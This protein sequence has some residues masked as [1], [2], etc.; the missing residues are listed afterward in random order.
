MLR[1]QSRVTHGGAT[2]I[3]NRSSFQLGL[4]AIFQAAVIAA[5]MVRTQS[6][7]QAGLR[8]S[9]IPAFIEKI[10]ARVR[11]GEREGNLSLETLTLGLLK[12][13]LA[14]QRFIPFLG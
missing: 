3:G 1:E 13:G 9:Q 12:D 14:F 2:T 7:S 4:A 10:M 6:L 8:V 11:G 5:R